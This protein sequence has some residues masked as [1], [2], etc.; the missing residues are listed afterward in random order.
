MRNVARG[1][2]L[3][4]LVAVMAAGVFYFLP[5]VEAVTVLAKDSQKDIQRINNEINLKTEYINTLDNL[6]IDNLEDEEE[7]AASENN[8]RTFRATAYCLRGKTA[9]GRA[10]RRGI[11]AA[12]TRVLPLGTR[13]HMSAGK[14]SGNYVV[15]DTGGKVKG[16]VLD[17]WVPSC[18]EARSWGRR[19]VQV[20]VLGKSKKRKKR[21]EE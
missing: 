3:L 17:I 9:S 21:E 2:V 12:D 19:S 7:A 15:A 5:K 16:R 14:Y 1:S 11:V 6:E 4:L 20:T 18:A 13:I 10:V 8:A